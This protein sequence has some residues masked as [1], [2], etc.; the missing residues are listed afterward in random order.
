MSL[1]K[2]I[3]DITT[4]LDS[5]VTLSTS[6]LQVMKN[7][8]DALSASNMAAFETSIIEKDKLLR[9]IET[10]EQSLQTKLQQ[11]GLAINK[12]DMDTLVSSCSPKDQAKLTGLIDAVRE[13]ATQCQQ[14]NSINSKIISSNQNN[15]Q[16]LIGILRGQSTNQENL[17][18]LSGKSSNSPNS[19]FLGSV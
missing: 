14:Q 11:N 17:Y 12:Q 7:E 3:E 16:K 9:E 10:I 15:I 8:H 19:Q 6:L 13:I 4:L 5:E 1:T 2:S 18:D